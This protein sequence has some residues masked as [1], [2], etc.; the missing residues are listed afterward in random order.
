MY[1]YIHIYIWKERERADVDVLRRRC[2][3]TAATFEGGA[4]TAA[5]AACGVNETFQK[6]D[7][8]RPCGRPYLLAHN[9]C[10]HVS[11]RCS[12]NTTYLT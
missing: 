2:A 9:K 7:A 1:I 8:Q 11:P 5:A 4:V 10:L 3:A 6:P 12:Y